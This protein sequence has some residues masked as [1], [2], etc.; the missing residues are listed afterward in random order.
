[1]YYK[2]GVIMINVYEYTIQVYFVSVSHV[3]FRF[4]T[5]NQTNYNINIFHR[6]NCMC[7]TR[8]ILFALR[9]LRFQ[10]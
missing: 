3:F 6:K 10:I 2:Y 5:N 8:A 1:M 7:S 9:V 4:R